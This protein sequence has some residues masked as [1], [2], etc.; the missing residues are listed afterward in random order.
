MA[1]F[2]T[3]RQRNKLFDYLKYSCMNFWLNKNFGCNSARIKTSAWV[4]LYPS[5]ARGCLPFG[6]T[7]GKRRSHILKQFSTLC[8]KAIRAIIAMQ[9]GV[10]VPGEWLVILDSIEADSDILAAGTGWIILGICKP[11]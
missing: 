7:L 11:N 10:Q 9:N 5:R 2:V 3:A 1:E 4:Q 8:T 6:S